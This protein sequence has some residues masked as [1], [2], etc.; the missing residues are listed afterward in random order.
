MTEARI[1]SREELIAAAQRTANVYAEIANKQMGSNLPIPV[2]MDFELCNKDPKA[3][4]RASDTMLV[5]INMILF[6]DNVLHILNEVIPHEIGHL[7]Q[8]DKFDLKGTSVQGHGAEW[9]EILRRL[10]KVPHKYH[11]LDITRAKEHYKA[12]K[13]ANKKKRVAE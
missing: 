3:A 6:E 8:Y 11:K 2:T 5:E 13:K 12:H 10:G 9:Q 1:Y 7:V 4:G